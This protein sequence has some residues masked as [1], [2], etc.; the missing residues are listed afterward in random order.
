MSVKCILQ[1]TI[2]QF[3]WTMCIPDYQRTGFSKFKRWGRFGSQGETVLD[4]THAHR[5]YL[6]D[7]QGL[8]SRQHL[9]LSW[10]CE[11][12]DV[13]IVFWHLLGSKLSYHVK[14]AAGRGEWSHVPGSK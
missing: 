1:S 2:Y 4:P 3:P 8:W 12:S 9:I 14:R 11:N 6:Y 10:Y 13:H 5:K 7:C